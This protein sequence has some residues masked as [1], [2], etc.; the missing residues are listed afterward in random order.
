MSRSRTPKEY[1]LAFALRVKEARSRTGLTQV[2]IAE[3]LQ[4]PQQTYAKYESLQHS[5]LLPHDLVEPFCRACACSI[6]WIISG[7]DDTSLASTRRARRCRS[8]TR[9]RTLASGEPLASQ[10]KKL[11]RDHIAWL[12]RGAKFRLPFPL[13][14]CG[15]RLAALTAAAEASAARLQSH[16]RAE[17]ESRRGVGPLRDVVSALRP[18]GILWAKNAS[19]QSASAGALFFRVFSHPVGTPEPDSLFRG[20]GD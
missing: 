10:N 6:E 8:G 14:R 13:G 18:G 20:R 3:L 12:G 16:D 9:M 11:A 5:R 7:A 4:I 19:Y 2:Q 15:L 17:L 1:R